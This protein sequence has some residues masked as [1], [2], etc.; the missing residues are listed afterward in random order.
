MGFG[1]AGTLLA[2]WAAETGE[3]VRVFL[4]QTGGEPTPPADPG[5]LTMTLWANLPLLTC[6]VFGVAILIGLIIIF[7]KN[8]QMAA[9]R[10][11]G[12]DEKLKGEEL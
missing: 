2:A 11:I 10:T 5:G 7:R 12:D 1:I 9:E 8:Q 3:S 4:A 6:L